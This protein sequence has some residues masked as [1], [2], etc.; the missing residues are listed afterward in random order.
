MPNRKRVH[1]R[2][3]ENLIKK[4]DA[5]TTQLEAVT[6]ALRNHELEK[7][8]FGKITRLPVRV[9]LLDALD[10]L[11]TMAY[12]RQLLL[13]IKAR[14]G[15]EIAPA[16]FGTASKDEER[17]F[18]SRRPHAVYLAH[19]LTSQRFEPIK[20]LWARSDWPIDK[21]IVAPTSGRVLY[22]RMTARICELALRSEE[23]AV[24]PEMMR[25]LAADH[26]RDLPGTKFRRGSFELELWRDIAIRLLD[27]LAPR[28]QELRSE[29]AER[30]AAL[31]PRE[32]LFGAEEPI[33]L[34]ALPGLGTPG[35][36][37]HRESSAT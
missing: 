19:G 3:R 16:R 18:D 35:G 37:K 27:D 15:R 9:A 32:Q 29:A 34:T 2:K 31:T 1:D 28:D 22:L 23:L 17:A 25:I 6:T 4:R 26:A 14:W 21:R 12:S 10:E 30:L 24:D 8:E 33:V 5:L 20:R 13:Y 11:G 36:T 7:S